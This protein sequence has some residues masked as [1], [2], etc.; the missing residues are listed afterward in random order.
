MSDAIL[1]DVVERSY[2]LII[3]GQ[4]NDELG[5]AS[6]GIRP[7]RGAHN[8]ILAG[9]I[10]DEAELQGL[11]QRGSDPGLTLLEARA[12]DN[13]SQR[14]RGGGPAAVSRGTRTSSRRLQLGA[15]GLAPWGR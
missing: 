15:G 9:R 1:G 8:T 11:L 5:L 2:R 13:L 3:G 10:R 7:T 4:L 12:N 14:R 6:Q